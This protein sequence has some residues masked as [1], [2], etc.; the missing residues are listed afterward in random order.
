MTDRPRL[1]RPPLDAALLERF[2]SGLLKKIDAREV[3][4]CSATTL[5]SLIRRGELPLVRVS[6]RCLRI[7]PSALREFIEARRSAPRGGR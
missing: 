5:E 2:P 3:L 7:E 4:R 1:L 6:A